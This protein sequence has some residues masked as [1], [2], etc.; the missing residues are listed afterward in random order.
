M[1]RYIE[2][3]DSWP[4]QPPIPPGAYRGWYISNDDGEPIVGPFVTE[5]EAAAEFAETVWERDGGPSPAIAT[6]TGYLPP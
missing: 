1:D 6:Q 4:W 3:S 5:V 2:H